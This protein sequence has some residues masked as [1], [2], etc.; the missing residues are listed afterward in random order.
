MSKA[1]AITEQVAFDA[2]TAIVTAA[3]VYQDAPAEVT[4][5][6]VIL[7]DMKSFRL[8]TKGGV[9]DRR[10]SISI[11]S[12]VEA[13][14]RAPLLEIQEQVETAL[15]GQTF[16]HQGWT[17]AFEFEDDD[18]ALTDDGVTYAGVTQFTVLAIAP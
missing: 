4:G 10:V 2:L 11:I 18:A 3:G 12:M 15:D 16:E 6:L 1:K 8:P 7:G 13:E 17:L 9:D 14:E 5:P